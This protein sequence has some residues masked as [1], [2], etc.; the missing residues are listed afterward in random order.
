MRY[1][2]H[3]ILDLKSFNNT[4]VSALQTSELLN[5]TYAPLI[6]LSNA[7]HL[8]SVTLR[9]PSKANH[10][11][12]SNSANLPKRS[13]TSTLFTIHFLRK[14]KLY[15]KLKY[16]R[17]PQ[18]DIVSGGFAA[19]F[20]GFIGFLISEK[21]GIELVDSGD[22]Y[23]AFMYAAFATLSIRPFLLT[24]SADNTKYHPLSPKYLLLFLRDLVILFLQTIKIYLKKI[25]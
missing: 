17:C 7:D 23:N 24:Y 13:L 2:K 3:L 8:T 11:W 18:Y 12:S 15:T 1:P 22:F 5:T 19:I 10:N 4:N 25:L 20:A 16:S 9:T 6:K 21:F 14:E